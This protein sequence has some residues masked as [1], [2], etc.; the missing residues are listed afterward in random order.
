MGCFLWFAA[1]LTPAAEQASAAGQPQ[2]AASAEKSTAPEGAPAD[3]HL[4]A[5][6]KQLGAR[7]YFVRQQAHNAIL[8]LGFAAFDALND[9]TLS[10]DLEVAARAKYLLRLIRV[11]WTQDSDPPEV[12]RQLKDYE[13][14][15][16]DDRLM[17]IHILARLGGNAGLPALCRL[18]RFE[19]SPVLA[20]RAALE[21]MSMGRPGELPSEK[22][23]ETLKAQLSDSHRP[24][25]QWLMVYADSR[26][27]PA[28]ALTAWQKH[29]EA[30]LQLLRRAPSQT[31]SRVA[32]AM[33]RLQINYLEKLHRNAE[34]VATMRRLIDLEKGDSE[35]LV[36][37][38]EWLLDQ[39]AWSV[40][41]EAATRFAAR[42]EA[43]P[44]LL[45]A[46]AAAQ[47]A[48]GQ[49][50]KAEATAA[51]ARKVNERSL[52]DALAVRLTLAR[53][54]WQRGLVRWAEREYRDVIARKQTNGPQALVAC[55]GLSEML[56]DQGEDLKASQVLE[57]ALKAIGGR[58][59]A[60]AEINERRVSEWRSRMHYF[61]ACHWQQ[62][63]N[64]AEF[65]KALDDA[66]QA[67]PSD[68]DVLIACFRVPHPTPEYRE[69]IRE[70]I[71]KAAADLR[72]K[73][74]EDQELAAQPANQFAWL[75]G[76]T[77]GDF[78][79]ALKFSKLSLELEPDA[80]GYYDTLAR[81]YYAKGDYEN[82]V[83][84]QTQAQELDPHS[85]LIKKQLALFQKALD[86][87]KQKSPAAK[88]AG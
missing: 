84:N 45:Y 72:A 33:L 70:N 38:I 67:D 46:A 55:Y 64:D 21:I 62:Q 36:E 69:T 51:R 34:A 15:S 52:D 73:I 61:R 2:P 66:L 83:K 71:R 19:A 6:I 59:P 85:G 22:V 8:K 10:D 75:V 27:D 35:T 58:R 4:E 76:N 86:E 26:G 77:E 5:L 78:D 63:G 32:V 53:R 3:A 48:Q 24:P 9:A 43:H 20:K 13:L 88:P 7:D 1:V 14:Q 41:D 49:K 81:V 44:F 18:V 30:E 50:E 79:E 28:A 87:Q 25:A 47:D 74:A 16:A 17:R 82:A 12:K 56:H 54:L 11:E 31:D 42:F 29:V 57:E 37:L 80:G 23:V 65:R 40:I 68:V 39:K 60:D